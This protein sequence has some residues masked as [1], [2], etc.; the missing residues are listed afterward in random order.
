MLAGRLVGRLC[1]SSISKA[2]PRRSGGGSTAGRSSYAFGSLA[3]SSDARM[4][5]WYWLSSSSLELPASSS[6]NM[7]LFLRPGS[8]TWMVS[9]SSA[10]PPEGERAL[11]RLNDF[12]SGEVTW[13]SALPPADSGSGELMR[14]VDSSM[15]CQPI[16][17]PGVPGMSWGPSPRSDH[18]GG[19]GGISKQETFDSPA[20]CGVSHTNK[21]NTTLLMEQSL[22]RS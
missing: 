12:L 17:S 11:S 19:T 16:C 4:G 5:A 10:A 2:L 21:K 14:D 15:A 7:T 20:R 8:S 1:G 9:L 13:L 18:F 22:G 3:T 6:V